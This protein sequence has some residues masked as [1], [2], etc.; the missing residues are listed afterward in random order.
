M[1][2]A[3]TCG[4]VL[5]LGPTPIRFSCKELHPCQ[6][7]SVLDRHWRN[8]CK[9]H[10]LD[11]F[12][13]RAINANFINNDCTSSSAFS[14]IFPCK[15]L[16]VTMTSR[17]IQAG[18]QIRTAYRHGYFDCDDGTLEK[19]LKKEEA[20]RKRDTSGDEV[21]FCVC[22]GDYCFYGRGF[23]DWI[24]VIQAMFWRNKGLEA[25]M[26]W[27]QCTDWLS[28]TQNGKGEHEILLTKCVT[29]LII[30]MVNLLLMV[31]YLQTLPWE[32]MILPSWNTFL[33]ALPLQFQLLSQPTIFLSF[34]NF[35]ACKCAHIDS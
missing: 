32:G 29:S 1:H 10:R 20:D 4:Q 12:E 35:F 26:S 8:S 2:Q 18:E 28:A 21:C 3:I 17:E 16:I 13:N 11:D 23:I 14:Q 25:R 6:C 19:I 7:N 33:C 31:F 27:F 5:V 24:S 22:K 34:L 30:N 15:A 9:I